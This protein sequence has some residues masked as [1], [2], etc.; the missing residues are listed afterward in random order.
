MPRTH[1]LAMGDGHPDDDAAFDHDL[2]TEE[3]VSRIA[4][5]VREGE[6][7][8]DVLHI[9]IR[10]KGT[11]V[12]PSPDLRALCD[13]LRTEKLSEALAADAFRAMRD[14]RRAGDMSTYHAI[15]EAA[16]PPTRGKGGGPFA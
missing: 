1:D 15:A 5:Q 14:A 2:T 6:I 7:D 8:G 16:A 4:T 3:V 9:T 10:T 12:A 13:R 11:D